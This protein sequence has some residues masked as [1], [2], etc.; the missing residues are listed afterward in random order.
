MHIKL[1]SLIEGKFKNRKNQ[2][3]LFDA[4]MFSV[5]IDTSVSKKDM[6]NIKRGA[7]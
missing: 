7:N 1:I 3:H 6:Y 5:Y 2:I 4:P